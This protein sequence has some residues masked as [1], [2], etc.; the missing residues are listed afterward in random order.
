[1]EVVGL[2]RDPFGNLSPP[3]SLGRHFGC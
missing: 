2:N 3:V 1:L